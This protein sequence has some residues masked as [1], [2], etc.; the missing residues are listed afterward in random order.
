MREVIMNDGLIRFLVGDA[1]VFGVFL[2]QILSISLL[3]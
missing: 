3:I 2:F 1:M